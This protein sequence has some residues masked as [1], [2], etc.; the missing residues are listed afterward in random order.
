MNKIIIIFGL[1][2]ILIA[3][4]AFYQ[5]NKTQQPQIKTNGKVTIGSQ[6]FE[7]EVVRDT[8]AQQIGLTK[9]NS[10][11]DT[12]GML[13]IFE[14]PGIYGFWM[15]NMK[16]SIDIIFI[17]NDTIVSIAQDAKPVKNDVPDPT[18]YHPEA[19]VDRV[20]EIHS[21]LSKKYNIKTGDKVKFEL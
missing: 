2:L 8:K 17:N 4:V 6:T 15:K 16:F 18:V 12:Q 10:I 3:G 20:L 11:K 14:Q 9:Y 21:G 1:A 5:F 19:P 13:F 7:V